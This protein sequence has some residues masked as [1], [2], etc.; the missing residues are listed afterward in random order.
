LPDFLGLSKRFLLKGWT[1][2]IS[3]ERDDSERSMKKPNFSLRSASLLLA[4]LCL[5][6]SAYAQ[7]TPSAD[8]YTNTADPTTNFGANP[9]LSVDGA[10]EIT[11]IQFNLSSIPSGAT[12][13]QA[14]LK[15]YV[16]AVTTPGTFN[17]DYVNGA[18]TERTI[19]SSLAPALGTAIVSGVAITGASKNQYILINVTPAVTA[20]LNKSTPNDGIALVADGTFNATFDSKENA[21]TS[22]PAELDIVFAEASGSGITGI[23]TAAGSGL[24]GGGTSGT[25]NLSMTNTCAT[26]QVLEWTS[27]GWACTSLSAGGT[28]TGVTAGTDLTGGGTS[29]NVTVNLNTANVPLLATPNIF[30]GSLNMVSDTRIDY[31]GL[32]KGSYTPAIRF[33]TGNTGEAIS[34]DRAGTVNVDGIDL[35]TGFAPRLSVTN[36]G[37]VGIG[38][39]APGATL[40]VHGTG[41]FTGTVTFAAGQAFPGAAT[42]GANTFTGNQTVNGVVSTGSLTAAGD[43]SVG[44]TVAAGSLTAT[45]NVSVGGSVSAGS[46]ITTGNVSATET[47]YAG[48]VSANNSTVGGNAISG[49]NSAASG[50]SNGGYFSSSS[51]QG[52]AVV[53]VNSGGGYGGYF[54]GNVAVTGNVSIG[55]DTPM[56]HNP[57]MIWSGFLVGNLG[58]NPGGGY[59]IPDQAIAVTRITGYAN[60]QGSGCSTLA[61]IILQHVNTFAF[62]E[63]S[64]P[65]G[66]SYF[67]S[68]PINVPIPAGTPLLLGGV[69]ASGCGLS[70]SSPSDVNVSVQY[71]MQ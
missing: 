24:I 21:T 31:N 39:T 13:S 68:G 15:L 42:L 55:G 52:T 43:V 35:Y 6:L 7:V 70:G 20:W 47:V 3:K 11:Y 60:G 61:Q 63:M 49:S 37:S 26:G 54:Q 59:L 38:T 33:G 57:H 29:G 19:T 69:A 48:S 25:L 71:V 2:S 27:G 9:L 41:N 30:T 12:I 51:P 14:T 5:S 8:A 66:T 44:A 65:N 67:D 45:G 10:T 17:V 34:S 64:L 4:T 23:T 46:L 1:I 28:I 58:N 32:N 56:S 22:H 16:N 36:G 40:D 50:T 53:G 18:W 62:Y